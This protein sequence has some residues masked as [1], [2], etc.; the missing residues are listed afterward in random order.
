[1]GQAASFEM[2]SEARTPGAVLKAAHPS[3]PPA[4]TFLP[5]QGDPPLEPPEDHLSQLFGQNHIITLWNHHD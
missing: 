2:G 1:M 4:A 3:H 5:G